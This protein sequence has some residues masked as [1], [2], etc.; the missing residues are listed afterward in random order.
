MTTHYNPAVPDEQTEQPEQQPEDQDEKLPLFPRRKKFLIPV[1]L[2]LSLTF[3]GAVAGLFLGFASVKRSDA[4][5]ATLTELNL[6]PE[7]Q[8]F[9]GE[10]F[11]TGYLVLGKHDQRNGTYDLTFTIQGN[12]GKAAVRSRCERDTDSDPWQVT[13]LDIGVG[14]RDGSVYTLVG[15]PDS[16]PGGGRE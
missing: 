9:V 7:V 11:D 12:V 5:K 8:L 13:Y 1:I 14:G 2:L 3:I 4:Y 15:D 10:P 16:P 6:H